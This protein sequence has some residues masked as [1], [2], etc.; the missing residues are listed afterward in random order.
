M[1]L[2]IYYRQGCIKSRFLRAA[3]R[4]MDWDL[5][6]ADVDDPQS[7]AE[8]IQ[9]KVTNGVGETPMAPA[10]WT[11]EAYSH[12]MY[13]IIEYLNDRSPTSMYPDQ[14][15]MKLYARTVIHRA[16]RRL[17]SIWPEYRE[18]NDPA[19]LL[20]YYDEIE[21]QIVDWVKNQKILRNLGESVRTDDDRPKN[22]N[23]M[24]LLFFSIIIEVNHLRPIKNTTIL[25]W[26]NKL[27]SQA[28]FTDL[29]AEPEQGYFRL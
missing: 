10:I 3:L 6:E 5:R 23:F 1:L 25:P 24:E 4:V 27:A 22:P 18:S 17:S 26:F 28:M 14:P 9:L 7:R 8:L 20:S 21:G 15:S 29:V 19:N 13:C 11:N 16:L 12:E 2:T